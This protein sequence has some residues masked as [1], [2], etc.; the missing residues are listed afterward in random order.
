[1]EQSKLNKFRQH[2]EQERQVLTERIHNM[3]ENALGVTQQDAISE[4]SSYDNHPADIGSETFERS[5]DFALRE[6]TMIQLEKVE[7]AL[8][9]IEQG[10]YGICEKCGRAIP[11]ERLEAMPSTTYCLQCKQ[12]DE[13]LPDRHPRPIEEDVI[14]GAWGQ[15]RDLHVD[16]DNEVGYDG[17]DTW[18]D[19]AVYTEHSEHSRAGAYYG[20]LDLDV[21]DRGTGVQ[22]IEGIPYVRGEDGMIYQNFKKLDDEDVPLERKLGDEE[23][24]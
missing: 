3:D 23:R 22:D 21:E 7:D 17:E 5:K 10:T 13:E 16:D 2:L 12:L 18:Q 4:L 9:Q 20:P 11:A 6:L 19:L 8:Q 15:L 1:M 14:S 24:A